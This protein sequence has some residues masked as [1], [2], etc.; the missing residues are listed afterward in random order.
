YNR[1][2]IY[3]VN[4]KYDMVQGLKCYKSISEIEDD[5]DLAIL[6]VPAKAVPAALEE[7][8]RKGVKAAI[9]ISGGFAEVGG[10]G[11][12]LQR[13]LEEVIRE[14][15]IRVIGPNCIGV[16]DNTTGMDT[17][18][19]P[20]ERLPRPPKGSVSIVSQSG[21]LLSMWMDWLAQIGLG[22]AKAVSYGNKVDVDDA[23]IIEYLAEDEDT[24]IILLYLEGLKPGRGRPFMDAVK[25]ALCKGKPL[26]VLKGGRTE[27]GG[28]AAASHTAAL[29]SGYEVYKSLF[30]QLG[31]IEVETMEEM[32][33]VAKAY[34]MAGA[35]RGRRLL[36]LTNA[37]GEG[38][39]ATDYAAQLG[40]DVPILPEHI[41]EK[42]RKELPP[43][44]VVNN[45]VD[46]TADTD[47]EKYKL[48]LETVL[49]EKLVDIVVA[50]APPHPPGMSGRVADYLAEAHYKYGVPVIAVATGGRLA[51][52]FLKL[53]ESRGIPSY[54]TP[55][56]AVRAAAGL[57]RIGEALRRAR[58]RWCRG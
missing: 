3:P 40:L 16:L 38:V 24:K 26:V 2:K 4:P 10:E 19:L 34:V 37:G 25:R 7:A 6:A 12:V 9:V 45:P 1:G 32:F 33:D 17:F 55:E 43:F 51:S 28:L 56:R 46:L 44:V 13:R 21:A 36:I 53:F 47:D 29:A 20:E 48:V 14:Y 54:P 41:K 5:V 57:A 52:A 42:L 15:G 58:R 31:V 49:A 8:A 27:R 30:R 23:D 18:F 22:I 11:A 39:L 50:I 35:A